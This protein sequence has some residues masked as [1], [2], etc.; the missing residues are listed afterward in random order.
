MGSTAGSGVVFGKIIPGP[1]E[2]RKSIVRS[3]SLTDKSLF[4]H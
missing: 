4:I 1:K 2:D 3:H